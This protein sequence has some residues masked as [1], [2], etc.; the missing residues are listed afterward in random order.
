M[1][2]TTGIAAATSLVQGLRAAA[3]YP[4]EVGEIRI[5]E[6][7]ISW[8]L[9][10]GTYAYKIKKPVNLGFLD[11]STLE[12][13]RH[14]CEEELR[15]NR[16][17]APDIYLDVVPI[18]GGVARPRWNGAGVATEYAVRMR[19]FAQDALAG[20]TLARGELRAEHIESFAET[21]AAFH[22]RAGCAGDGDEYG[23]PAAVWRPV[24]HNF[25]Q[26]A[27]LLR[28]A[29]DL[30]RLE[31]LRAWSAA[32]HAALENVFVQRKGAGR[33][34][35]CHGDLHLANL[36]M[37]HGRIAAFDCL[38][39]A[40]ELRWIDVMNEVAF[41]TMDLA[42]RGRADLAACFL[43]AYLQ[44]SG[45]YDGL[46]TLRYYQVYRALVRAK[47]ARLRAQQHAADKAAAEARRYLTLAESFTFGAA[48][49]LVITHG[50]SGAGKTTLTADLAATLAAVRVRSDV[51]RKRLY[52]Y[53]PLERTGSPP[54]GGVYTSEASLRTYE[55]LARLARIII[56]SGHAAVI[57]AA[58]LK[59]EQRVMF[60]RLARELGVPF[61]ILHADAAP[62]ALR[63]RV[64]QRAAGARDAS[65]A[66]LAVLEE[67]LQTAEPLTD[68][69]REYVMVVRTDD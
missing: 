67:Q 33:V 7:H 27:P 41:L 47:V 24:E 19:E 46:A 42:D 15:L 49:P 13:R 12:K 36:V 2:S 30:A 59:R 62:E 53:A 6:T 9:L 20:E 8:V 61:K 35:E 4:H 32:H 56:G 40:P 39:F 16:R 48:T 63:A 60:E 23:A 31:R 28:E 17:L 5:I 54:T 38:E 34:R 18:T 69:E 55:R 14:F 58:F 11:F 44:S 57:D 29:D 37:L 51:E 68:E 10:T 3:L 26:L 22:A 1:A 21:I 45:D 65:E 64:K 43:S 66:D 25:L 52:G 50:L